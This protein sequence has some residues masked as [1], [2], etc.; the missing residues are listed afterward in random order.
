MSS[1]HFINKSSRG[2]VSIELNVLLNEFRFQYSCGPHLG[3]YTPDTLSIVIFSTEN[4]SESS[5]FR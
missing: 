2:K 1:R 5:G 4:D 3:Y